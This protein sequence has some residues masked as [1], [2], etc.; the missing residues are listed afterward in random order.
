MF[1]VFGSNA[2]SPYGINQI[3]PHLTVARAMV[4]ARKKIA[5][6]PQA[7]GTP[8]FD[9]GE[10]LGNTDHVCYNSSNPL[11]IPLENLRG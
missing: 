7:P 8:T 3:N 11:V 9:S 4:K 6:S 1:V 10:S 5:T 2:P